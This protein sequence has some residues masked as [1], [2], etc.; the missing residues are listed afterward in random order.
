MAFVV[1]NHRIIVYGIFLGK[2][3]ESRNVR[4]IL[5]LRK[6]KLK[7]LVNVIS[8]TFNGPKSPGSLGL[9]YNRLAFSCRI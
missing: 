2:V 6:K 4:S 1:G 3:L 7:L 9:K 5:G 8:K